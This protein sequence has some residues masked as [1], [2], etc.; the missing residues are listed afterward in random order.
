[1]LPDPQFLWIPLALPCA[2]WHARRCD[3]IYSSSSPTSAHVLGML[4]SKITRKPWIADYRDE[5]TLN[6]QWFPPTRFHC[7]LGK[8]LDAACVR[9]AAKVIN[10]TEARTK[11]FMEH[12]D[13]SAEK[14]VTIH[15][16]YDEEDMKPW[17]NHTPPTEPLLLCS[18]GS[19]YGGRSPLTFLNA[20]VKLLDEKAISRSAIRLTLVGSNDQYLADFIKRV[21]IDDMVKL[22]GR[23]NQ[24]QAFRCLAES[25]VSLLFGS[26]MERVA[27]TTKVYEYLGMY[28]PVMALVPE[29]QLHDFIHQYGGWTAPP[30]DIPAI[31]RCL[32]D[33]MQQHQNN[34]L[35]DNLN[36]SMA[37]KYTRHELTR[38]LN[39]LF[40][41]VIKT[42]C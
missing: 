6:S 1:M 40:R 38:Q 28:K 15:N 10:V 24:Q 22:L 11:L 7:W 2:C 35:Y 39:T 41:N 23:V 5:W 27:M 29:G 30:D 36:I 21:K 33:L 34:S 26:D 17:R 20:I 18:I 14:F 32:L 16:G 31:K 3:I 4:A 13:E 12:F 37:D 9:Q 19:F 8:K 25:H 42:K